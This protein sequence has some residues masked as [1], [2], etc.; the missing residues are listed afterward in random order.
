MNSREKFLNSWVNSMIQRDNIIDFSQ[1]FRNGVNLCLLLKA[2]TEN[3]NLEVK[4]NLQITKKLN[5]FKELEMICL[6]VNFIECNLCLNL[7]GTVAQEIHNGNL[8][9]TLGLVWI[10]YHKFSKYNVLT[11]PESNT[12]SIANSQY[13]NELLIEDLVEIT[14]KKSEITTQTELKKSESIVEVAVEVKPIPVLQETPKLQQ[15]QPRVM[16]IVI[17][18]STSSSNISPTSNS[19]VNKRRSIESPHK[20]WIPSGSATTSFAALEITPRKVKRSSLKKP[21]AKLSS[22]E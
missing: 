8:K 14:P 7:P 12:T 21:D 18:E 17:P 16:S 6:A 5:K 19:T 15:A 4:F 3:M 9:L 11:K 10:L 2:I 13:I 1:D 20:R 22:K